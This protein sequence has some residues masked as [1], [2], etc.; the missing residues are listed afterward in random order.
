[1]I[2]FVDQNKM[3]VI[4]ISMK[5]K[6]IIGKFPLAS[7]QDTDFS[8]LDF[9]NLPP[10]ILQIYVSIVF[11]QIFFLRGF[12]YYFLFFFLR[13][14]FYCFLFLFLR[15]FFYCFLF[16]FLWL[17]FFQI[18]CLFIVP[19]LRF[20]LCLFFVY[21]LN[22]LRFPGGFITIEFLK[23]LR[24]RNIKVSIH[25]LIPKRY[26]K[27]FLGIT[28]TKPTNVVFFLTHLTDTLLCLSIA[29]SYQFFCIAKTS[30]AGNHSNL[31][32]SCR[33]EKYISRLRIQ[34]Y[35]ITG[36]VFIAFPTQPFP[37]YRNRCFFPILFDFYKPDISF[38][39]IPF[40]FIQISNKP[41]Q[42]YPS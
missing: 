35:K 6:I 36:N 34:F 4:I 37:M 5:Q 18:F 32:L 22:T 19:E 39:L 3:P 25:F 40:I 21:T 30:P 16:F 7:W 41:L 33:N 27:C 14:L 12:F 28:K 17:F 31:Y 1:M 42:S 13:E 26:I 24:P 15:G 20:Y 29:S 9:H 38:F 11:F 23:D 10:E 8:T 2:T